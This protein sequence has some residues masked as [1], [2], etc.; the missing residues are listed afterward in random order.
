MEWDFGEPEPDFTPPP[1]AEFG[2]RELVPDGQHEFEIRSAV[3]GRHKWREGDYLMLQLSAVGKRYSLVFCDI[4]KGRNGKALAGTLAQALSVDATGK[5]RLA[6]E[7]IEGR[8]VWAETY[9]KVGKNGKTYVNV[10]RFVPA[11]PPAAPP[12]KPKPARPAKAAT[13]IE[14]PNDDIPF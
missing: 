9:Q 14:Y 1:P 8:R 3:E 2:E 10:R 7:D 13:K 5:V 4:E 11:A 12:D 6:P